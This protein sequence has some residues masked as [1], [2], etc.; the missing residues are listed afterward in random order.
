MPGS[1]FTDDPYSSRLSENCPSPTWCICALTGSPVRTGD[2]S[3]GLKM[4]PTPS[5]M[6]LRSLSR[7]SLFCCV[8]SGVPRNRL[9]PS[10]WLGCW[11]MGYL[12]CMHGFKAGRA[13]VKQGNC[14]I[15]IVAAV[16]GLRHAP[17]V[18]FSNPAGFFRLC[19]AI[20]M[21]ISKGGAATV[22][23]ASWVTVLLRGSRGECVLW[24]SGHC[25]LR[26]LKVFPCCK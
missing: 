16:I 8:N 5:R 20:I 11:F 15:W 25:T 7:N 19:V 26:Y 21:P 22:Q 24:F 17:S 14:R 3:W 18:S 6:A 1:I 12:A 10:S 4:P 23:R 13:V 2:R 9:P